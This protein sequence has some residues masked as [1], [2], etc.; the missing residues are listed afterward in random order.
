MARA[1]RT[2]R[3][4]RDTALLLDQQETRFLR[5][6]LEQYRD[7]PQAADNP[8]RFLAEGIIVAI[9]TASDVLE[10]N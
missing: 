3:L 2:T 5:A 7:S 1:H 9:E 6:L 10:S 8:H 4:V